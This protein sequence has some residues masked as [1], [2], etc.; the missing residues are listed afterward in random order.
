MTLQ[1]RSLFA[2]KVLLVCHWSR[3]SN[4]FRAPYALLV[5]TMIPSL[6]NP[7]VGGTSLVRG[8]PGVSSLLLRYIPE[9][10]GVLKWDLHW[11]A[12]VLSTQVAAG[13]VLGIAAQVFLVWVIIGYV[14]PW[15]VADL[16]DMARAVAAFTLP[17]RV[18]SSSRS[19][20][21]RPRAGADRRSQPLEW[22]PSPP[23][24]TFR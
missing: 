21:R 23:R 12:T 22:A 2:A 15:L 20:Y 19:A 5:S 18:G 16:L 9:R 8:L 1:T 6:V 4:V 13:A 14:M 24:R 11:V 17:A 10:G 7:V 3:C